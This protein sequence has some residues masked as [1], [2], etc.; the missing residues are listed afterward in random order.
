MLGSV[1]I[2]QLDELTMGGTFIDFNRVSVNAARKVKKFAFVTHHDGVLAYIDSKCVSKYL[3][4]ELSVGAEFH[5][6]EGVF[7]V[8]DVRIGRS[9]VS[10]TLTVVI[11]MSKSLYEKGASIPSQWEN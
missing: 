7:R 5:L 2:Q 10:G 4:A 6:L 8:E 9:H 3:V 1:T 11:Y